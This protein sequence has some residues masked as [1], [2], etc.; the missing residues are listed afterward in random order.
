MMSSQI[1]CQLI[2]ILLFLQ[3]L[4]NR[5]GQVVRCHPCHRGD[6]QFLGYLLHLVRLWVQLDQLVPSLLVVL[7][8][9]VTITTSIIERIF[10]TVIKY[11]FMRIP[12]YDTPYS[13]HYTGCASCNYQLIASN[14]THNTSQNVTLQLMHSYI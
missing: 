5:V 2:K 3:F 8:H 14:T 7:L 10:N 1:P 4:V 13:K 9:P 11:W 6:H 12:S